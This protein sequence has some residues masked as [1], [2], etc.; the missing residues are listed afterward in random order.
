MS[1]RVSAFDQYVFFSGIEEQLTY[2]TV[3]WFTLRI[4]V[5][6]TEEREE[7]SLSYCPMHWYRIRGGQVDYGHEPAEDEFICLTTYSFMS[8][9]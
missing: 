4:A 8:V 7:N 3:K 1:H 9:T 2:S 6:Q 5:A